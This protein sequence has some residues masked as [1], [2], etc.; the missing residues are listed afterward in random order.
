MKAQTFNNTAAQ[1]D[2]FLKRV[3]AIPSEAAKEAPTGPDYVLAHS[4]TGHNH[5]MAKG[6]VGL[7]RVDEFT[8]FIEVTKTTEL[9]HLRAHDTHAPIAVKPG[10]YKVTRQ[11]EYTPEG[12]R[13]AQ[14]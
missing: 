6:H 2:V 14:D 11:R 12:F 13:L 10:K 4:E 7:F 8:S 5:V 1:G 9:R 3:E